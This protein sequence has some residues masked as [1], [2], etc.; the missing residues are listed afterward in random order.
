MAREA[1]DIQ[2]WRRKFASAFRLR[3][4][5]AHRR[6][7]LIELAW[8]L[9]ACAIAVTLSPVLDWQLTLDAST[10][11][12]ALIALV[13]PTLGEELLFRVA[14]LPLPDGKRSFPRLPAIVSIALFVLWHPL[15]GWFAGSERW[16]IFTD[17]G[18]LFAVL[19][20]GVACTRAYWKSGSIWPCVVLH[21][22][23]V[24]CWKIFA[25][26]PPLF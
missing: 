4:P 14:M 1:S 3:F 17:P 21:W 2:T 15:Q 9:P 18:F 26:G 19:C 25:G 5:A 12:I 16:T 7:T 6:V 10:L 23:V 20:L 24:V 13:I 11:K 22:L 8:L